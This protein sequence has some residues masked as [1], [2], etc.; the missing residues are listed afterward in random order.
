MIPDSLIKD[1]KVGIPLIQMK[2]I[3]KKFGEFVANDNI[4][5]NVRKREIHSLLGENG[6]GKTTLMKS[7][8]GLLRPDSGDIYVEGKKVQLNSSR[9]AIKA[10]IGMVHQ[11][12]MLISQ[13]TV[14]EN[15]ILGMHNPS[16]PY[17]KD[18]VKE[19]RKWRNPFQVIEQLNLHKREH[20]KKIE[21]VANSYNLQ[22]NLNAKIWQLSVGE[23]QRVEIIKAVYRE[24]RLLILDEPSSNLTPNEYQKLF[25]VLQ[26]MVKDGIS[27]VLITHNL[28]EAMSISDRITVLRSGRLIGTLTREEYS[29]QKL[30]HMVVGKEVSYARITATTTL[31]DNDKTLLILDKIHAENDSGLAAVRDISLSV[32]AGEILGI[33]GIE[34]NGQRELVEVIMGLRNAKG[35]HISINDVDTTKLNT[36]EI[37][38]KGVAY[39]PQDRNLEGLVG[40]FS[41]WENLILDRYNESFFSGKLLIRV[42]ECLQNAS[43]LINEY[44]IKCQGPYSKAQTLSGGNAQRVVI[45]RELSKNP[46]L[47]V[48]NQP[49]RGL[50]I[51]S[52]EFVLNKLAEYRNRGCAVLFLSTELD[53]LLRISD[54]IAVIYE[55]QIQGI[56]LPAETDLQRI[57]SLMLGVS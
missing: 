39:I 3:T 27:I 36:G 16:M 40:E 56:V 54:R 47:I 31:N 18:E 50:D 32:S 30:T 9:D 13:L 2:G 26:T 25:L 34:G 14:L 21:K 19:K 8:Y 23:R 12:F 29:Q 53:Q 28:Q 4:D 22:I 42:K 35:G 57:G 7:L 41:I 20:T 10:G 51:A 24:A 38:K 48:A 6:A 43:F 1:D 37:I 33:A 46:I 5:F 17:S 15:I 45:A 52:T 11:H 49:T 55:G 44:N